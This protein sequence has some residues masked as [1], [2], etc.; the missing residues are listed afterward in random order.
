MEWEGKRRKGGEKHEW[1]ESWRDLTE[2]KTLPHTGAD[3]STD[4]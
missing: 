4:S 3:L 2:L 1:S